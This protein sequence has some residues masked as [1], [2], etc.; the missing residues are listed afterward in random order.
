MT[1][2]YK[3]RPCVQLDPMPARAEINPIE[4]LMVA[5]AVFGILCGLLLAADGLRP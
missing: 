3:R 4:V 2:P 5:L 1:S